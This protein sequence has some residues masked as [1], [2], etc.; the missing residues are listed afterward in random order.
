[1]ESLDFLIKDRR[2]KAAVNNDPLSKPQS[3][4]RSTEEA[5][6]AI[7]QS[8]DTEQSKAHKDG[9]DKTAVKR[10][11]RTEDTHSSFTSRK[12]AYNQGKFN[13]S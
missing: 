12:R 11:A 1:M 4:P 9:G 3:K 5:L 7:L 8:P 6:D 2:D 13:F 10:K